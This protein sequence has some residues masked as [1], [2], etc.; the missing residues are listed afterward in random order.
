MSTAPVM[1]PYQG[2][3]ASA[4]DRCSAILDA[5]LALVLRVGYP[6][7][8]VQDLAEEA[9]IGKGTVYRHWTSK[10]DILDHLL[11]REFDR[12]HDEYEANLCRNASLVTLS[13]TGQVLYRMMMSNP[14]LRAYNTGDARAL[15]CHVAF[16]GSPDNLGI[17]LVSALTGQEYLDLL[18]K[19]GLLLE[20]AFSLGGRVS[21]G[22]IVGGF[23]L[24]PET[25]ADPANCMGYAPLLSTVLHRGF[26]PEISPSPT[27][28][29]QAAITLLDRKLLRTAATAPRCATSY[30]L[31]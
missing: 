25:G 21:I 29:E 6:K 4:G 17:S 10:E 14:I 31:R 16:P 15:G 20:D 22:A 5:M 30:G 28:I 19:H 13:S 24:R 11:I 8:T 2:L 1:S 26:E 18:K 3:E 23:L 27:A 9:C 12:V 7:V